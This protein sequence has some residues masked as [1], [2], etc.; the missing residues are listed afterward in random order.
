MWL[1]RRYSSRAGSEDRP[2]KTQEIDLVWTDAVKV[3][4]DA[5]AERGARRYDRGFES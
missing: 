2:A 3:G 5:H 1:Y 4:I